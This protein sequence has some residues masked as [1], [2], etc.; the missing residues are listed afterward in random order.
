MR[1]QAVGCHVRDPRL[2]GAG[3]RLI[4]RAGRGVPALLELRR[5]FERERPLEGLRVSA[6]LPVT[7]ETAN[8]VVALR[9][10]GA[11]VVLCASDPV[12]TDDA[13]AAALATSR[14]VRTYAIEGE[15]EDAHRSHIATVL[16]HR[17]DLIVD[18]AARLAT[19][20][21]RS[22]GR[23]LDRVLGA[24]EHTAAGTVRLKAM[25]ARG[26][27][28]YPVIAVEEADTDLSLAGQALALE[29]LGSGARL[30]RAVHDLPVEIRRELRGDPR[31][32]GEGVG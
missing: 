30:G 10:G 13:V 23:L 24:T 20:L 26:E 4:D 29:Y 7:A 18:E 9:A 14:G 5:R 25:A 19:E 12:S 27:L 6:F 28:R 21:H 11:D 17:P 15:D 3:E 22:G 2:A 16:A 31:A 8:L 32:V 1:Q